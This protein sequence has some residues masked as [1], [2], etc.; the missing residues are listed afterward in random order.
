MSKKSAYAV[1]S[2]SMKNV[3]GEVR[4]LATCF[5]AA[6]EVSAINNQDVV[7][8]AFDLYSQTRP[9]PTLPFPNGDETAYLR[10]VW[11]LVAAKMCRWK[12]SELSDVND[13]LLEKAASLETEAC[14]QG[15]KLSKF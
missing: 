3:E 14:K 2:F 5:N 9:D 6:V 8:R 7:S 10:S 12:R 15:L 4:H 11:L 13:A 1:K